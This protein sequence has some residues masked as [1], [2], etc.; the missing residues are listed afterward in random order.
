MLEAIR[1]FEKISKEKLNYIIGS[2]REGD[3]SAIYSDTNLS[4]KELGW[5]PKFS[6]DEMMETAWKWEL[7]QRKEK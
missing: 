4:E 5:K 6:L 1:A 7:E 3:V 2:K